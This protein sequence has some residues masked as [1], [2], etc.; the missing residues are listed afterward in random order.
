VKI[1]IIFI[2]YKMSRKN[3]LTYAIRNADKIVWSRTVSSDGLTTVYTCNTPAYVPFGEFSNVIIGDSN[4]ALT[5]VKSAFSDTILTQQSVA[6]T[7]FYDNTPIEGESIIVSTL[8]LKPIIKLIPG[9]KD[10]YTITFK[11]ETS[12]DGRADFYQSLGNFANWTGRAVVKYEN[13]VKYFEVT[14]VN[15]VGAF[16]DMPQPPVPKPVPKPKPA[17]KKK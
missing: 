9:S 1:K 5:V 8:N 17:H 6:S 2:K 7:I 3:V 13:N 16:P 12:T 10:K 4:I 11:N 15:Y 14:Y